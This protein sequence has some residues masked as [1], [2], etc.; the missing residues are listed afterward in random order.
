M[1]GPLTGILRL[2]QIC[3]KSNVYLIKSVTELIIVQIFA[4]FRIKSAQ[5]NNQNRGEYPEK[6]VSKDLNVYG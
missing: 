4:T 3:L 2:S 6:N 1:N 5:R